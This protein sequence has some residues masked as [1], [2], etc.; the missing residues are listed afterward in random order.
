MRVHIPR[1]WLGARAQ[2]GVVVAVCTSVRGWVHIR[3]WS[4]LQSCFTHLLMRRYACEML[5]QRW[6]YPFFEEIS[7]AVRN[8]VTSASQNILV[9]AI[10]I[11]VKFH[12]TTLQS[13]LLLL[14]IGLL[15]RCTY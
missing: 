8:H 10:G 6:R 3:A 5:L 14:T 2:H 15:R 4:G 12:R 13:P 11:W 7:A 1:A 9:V